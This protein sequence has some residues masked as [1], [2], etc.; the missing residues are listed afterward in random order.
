MNARKVALIAGATGVVGRNFLRQLV[1]DPDWDVIALSRRPIDVEGTYR[2]ISVDLLDPAESRT[3]LGDNF[4][5]DCRVIV[6][7]SDDVLQL[8][9]SSLFRIEETWHVFTVHDGLASLT[10]V[11]VGHNNGRQAESI[12]GVE[13]GSIVIIHPSDTLEDGVAVEQR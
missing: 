2:H 3:P 5:V 8:P 10:P 7:H 6:W 9:T 12:S 13:A 1:G 11:E 4:R